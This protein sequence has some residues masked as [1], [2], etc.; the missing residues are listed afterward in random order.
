[1]YRYRR[2]SKLQRRRRAAS[3]GVFAAVLALVVG[4]PTFAAADPVN[5]VL[6]GVG[7]GSGGSGSGG[8]AGGGT[9][10]TQQLEPPP[11]PEYT[12]P[13]HGT[14]P[15]GQGTTAVID[16]TPQGQLPYTSDPNTSGEDLVVGSSRG[17]QNDT[18]GQYHGS[19]TI[20]F[21]FGEPIIQV[22]TNPGETKSG[23]TAQLNQGLNELCTQ[24]GGQLCISLL[25]MQSSTTSSGSTNHFE[26]AGVAVGGNQGIAARALTS[27]GNISSDGTCQ[28][29]HGDSEVAGATLGSNVAATAFQSESNSTACNN[30][31]APTQSNDSSAI[32]LNQNE[33]LAPCANG[34]P[35]TVVIPLAPILQVICNADDSNGSQDSTPYGVRESLTA[36]A[37]FFG[38]GSSGLSRQLEPPFL[39]LIKGT[40][41]AAESHAVAPPAQVTPGAPPPAGVALAPGGG[42]KGGGGQGGGGQGGAGAGGPGADAGGAGGAGAAAAAAGPGAGELAFTGADLLALGLVGGALILGG[43]ALTTAAGRRHRQTV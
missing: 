7:A 14:N 40:T 16:I 18:T 15:H 39:S 29:S 37:L 17:E 8:T 27:N 24:S 20:A 31:T 38:G 6:N 36:L 12:P 23:P 33:V 28:T 2:R 3:V 30:G 35:D 22:E 41:A 32:V 43:L 34:T 1:M 10:T 13:L 11:Q 5:D 9:A 42:V 21:L 26:G 25:D 4:I 19:V